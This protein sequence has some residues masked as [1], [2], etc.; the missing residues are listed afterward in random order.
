MAN[1]HTYTEEFK[2]EA[3]EYARSSDQPRY[4]IAETLGI[5]QGTLTTWISNAERDE[6]PGALSGDERAE[7]VRLR[8][9]LAEVEQEKQ[10]LRKA[11]AY[12]AK[13]TTR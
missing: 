1:R 9:R 11:A 5:S 8:K 7:L 3:V 12:F 4:K 13:E 10:I 6:Q 2:R